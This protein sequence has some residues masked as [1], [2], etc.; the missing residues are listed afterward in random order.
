MSSG[1]SPKVFVSS[2]CYDFAQVRKDLREFFKDMGMDPIMSEFPL[3]PIDHRS[4]PFRFG[5]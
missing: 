1:H 3:F 4:S 5:C 2:A